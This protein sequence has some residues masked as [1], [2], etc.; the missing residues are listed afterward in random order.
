[1]R[2]TKFEYSSLV[3]MIKSKSVKEVGLQLKVGIAN[4]KTNKELQSLGHDN[5]TKLIAILP[6][7][8]GTSI[9]SPVLTSIK[10]KARTSLAGLRVPHLDPESWPQVYRMQMRINN[11]RGG[12]KAG[13]LG[14][15]YKLHPKGMSIATPIRG[16]VTWDTTNGGDLHIMGPWAEIVKMLST[17]SGKFEAKFG[18]MFDSDVNVEF[19]RMYGPPKG[20]SPDWFEKISAMPLY[21][22]LNTGALFSKTEDEGEVVL[23]APGEIVDLVGSK[24][25]AIASAAGPSSLGNAAL[26]TISEI[27]SAIEDH[28]IPAVQ[29]GVDAYEMKREENLNKTMCTLTIGVGPMGRNYKVGTESM[30]GNDVLAL[31]RQLR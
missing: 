23:N 19:D 25:T 17:S 8:R 12:I 30:S 18:D 20:D 3:S 14:Q 7:G 21:V 29:M 24:I 1:M 15:F 10:K 31:A 28:V 13:P 6:H 22:T 5:L 9:T 4:L 2:I 26:D 27:K 11:S 16:N